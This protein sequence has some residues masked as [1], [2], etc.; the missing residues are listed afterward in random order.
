M[1]IVSLAPT[2]ADLRWA[3]PPDNNSPIEKYILERAT[4]ENGQATSVYTLQYSGP[5][6]QVQ[7]QGLQSGTS[8]LFRLAA[9]NQVRDVYLVE[10]SSVG[11]GGRRIWDPCD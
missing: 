4:A 10:V 7:C 3:P 11:L 1:Q 2:S 8:Y 6:T 5:D 9:Y